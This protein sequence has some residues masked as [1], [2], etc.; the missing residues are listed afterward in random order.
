MPTNDPERPRIKASHHITINGQKVTVNVYESAE[1]AAAR[2]GKK[3]AGTG[4]VRLKSIFQKYREITSEEYD[5]S[6]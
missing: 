1:E 6:S 3:S 2:A 4:S 5:I